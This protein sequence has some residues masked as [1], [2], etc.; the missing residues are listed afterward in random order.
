MANNREKIYKKALELI[1]KHHLFF[2]EDVIAMLPISKPTFYDYFKI[3]SNEL[4]SIKELLDIEK[5]NMK[6]KLRAKM[7]N[8]KTDTATLA[9]YK[10]IC[11]DEERMKL[12][13]AYVDVSTQGESL[14]RPKQLELIISKFNTSK[15]E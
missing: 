8:S 14:N 1:P 6:V 12:S 10:L 4:N 3:D 9:L 2:I 13:Q 11:S 5:V 7:Y 15:S